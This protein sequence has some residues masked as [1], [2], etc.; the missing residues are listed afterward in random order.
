MLFGNII[1]ELREERERDLC[2]DAII[3]AQEKIVGY[4]K[5]PLTNREIP[6]IK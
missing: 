4:A 2:N 1:I 3:V 6:T 5:T